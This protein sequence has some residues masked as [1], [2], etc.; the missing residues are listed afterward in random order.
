MFLQIAQV[1]LGILPVIAVVRMVRP[2]TE[3]AEA[4][5]ISVHGDHPVLRFAFRFADAIHACAS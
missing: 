2:V 1:A 3:V 4:E 5:F